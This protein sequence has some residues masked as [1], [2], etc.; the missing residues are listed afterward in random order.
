MTQQEKPLVSAFLCERVL[1]EVDGPQTYVRVID[2]L[3]GRIPPGTRAKFSVWLAVILKSGDVTGKFSVG[4]RMNAPDGKVTTL[5]ED[6]PVTLKGGEHGAS[7]NIGLAIDVAVEG[8]YGV[9]V[10]LDGERLTR[11]PFRVRLEPV[12]LGHST[13]SEQ[14]QEQSP[15]A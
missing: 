1:T 15:P 10:L 2:T 3:I 7:L 9:D 5:G 8:L 11:V 4:F 6:I 12:P 13:Q 14:N